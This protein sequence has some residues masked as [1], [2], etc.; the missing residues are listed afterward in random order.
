MVLNYIISI[1]NVGYGTY[2][3]YKSGIGP[4][5]LDRGLPVIINESGRI[6]ISLIRIA[7]PHLQPGRALMQ[8]SSQA[9]VLPLPTLASFYVPVA[10][11]AVPSPG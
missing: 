9:S 10:L 7:Y 1:E 6:S 3:T 11:S 5:D 2:S 4:F 8:G